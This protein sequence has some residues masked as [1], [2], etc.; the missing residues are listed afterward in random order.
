MAET[1]AA[2]I[3]EIEE[4]VE[5]LE[6]DVARALKAL[7]VL[8]GADA[9]RTRSIKDAFDDLAAH[10]HAEP[11]P[12]PTETEVEKPRRGRPSKAEKQEDD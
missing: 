2:L 3:K 1:P 5:Q 11:D 7:E 12:E 6:Q 9:H 10:L 8:A 4:R